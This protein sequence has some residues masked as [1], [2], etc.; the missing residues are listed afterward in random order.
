LVKG[1]NYSSV[2]NAA[3]RIPVE[4]GFTSLFKGALPTVIL[5]LQ[6]IPTPELL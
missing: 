1:R 6:V 4:E 5:F 2:F 3:N